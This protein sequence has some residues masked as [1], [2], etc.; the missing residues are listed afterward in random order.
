METVSTTQN[1]DT[2]QGSV[3]AATEPDTVTTSAGKQ[4]TP[5]S[6][7][8]ASKPAS[9]ETV[10]TGNDTASTQ[11][12]KKT[13]PHGS[14]TASTV[15]L[16]Y[17]TPQSKAFTDSSR[18]STRAAE[19]TKI[20]SVADE[21]PVVATSQRPSLRQE[22]TTFIRKI[23]VN[24][25][26]APESSSQANSNVAKERESTPVAVEELLTPAREPNA[27]ES[28]SFARPNDDSWAAGH[29]QDDSAIFFTVIVT[30]LWLASTGTLLW[31]ASVFGREIIYLPK[32]SNVQ[33][34]LTEPSTAGQNSA[35]RSAETAR[36]NSPGQK[37]VNRKGVNRGES[38]TSSSGVP[39]PKIAQHPNIAPHH[40]RPAARV[41][42][43]PES[44]PGHASPGILSRKGSGLSNLAELHSPPPMHGRKEGESGRAHITMTQFP[45]LRTPSK[46]K[47]RAPDAN[48]TD[49]YMSITGS[50][51]NFSVVQLSI[52]SESESGVEGLTG[53]HYLYGNSRLTFEPGPIRQGSNKS[54]RS[55]K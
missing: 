41:N 21:L 30:L 50:I 33:Q 29:S 39:H 15:H 47:G 8:V 7:V 53:E 17:S 25:S 44:A 31:S 9:K 10:P 37:L 13:T 35:V 49:G 54:I 11:A 38:Y 12:S 51:A 5:I 52:V 14:A 27:E 42:A 20:I 40:Q 26:D 23:K 1:K 48:E 2:L 46:G 19:T 24:A 18:S 4:T 28:K 3:V 55:H 45:Q 34:S 6:S 32:T 43:H 16:P 22:S 36:R